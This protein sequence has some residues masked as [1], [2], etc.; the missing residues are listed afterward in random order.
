VN[1]FVVQLDSLNRR[2]AGARARQ[3]REFIENRLMQVQSELDSARAA[4]EAFQME[5][6]AVD[7]DEQTRLAVEQAIDLKTRLA[8]IEVQEQLLAEKM[9]EGNAELRE[10]RRRKEL[11][12]KELTA[13]ERSN[14]DSSFFSLP[15]ASIPV[16]RGEYEELYSRVRVNESLHQSL[17][18]HLE[19]A[20]IQS[21]D[22]LPSITV[23]DKAIP[24]T[25]KSRPKRSIIVGGT[26]FFALVL[27]L[28]ISALLEHIRGLEKTRPEDYRRAR[29]F[30]KAYFGWLPAVRKSTK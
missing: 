5:H 6:R 13:L 14:R 29:A 16:L 10:L 17:L 26:F 22:E 15:I 20:K 7:F 9:S 21:Q 12:T 8:N 30:L 2:I 19:Q 18:S 24:P 23:L 27:A 4:F 11:L 28:L 25:L 3:T 1:A